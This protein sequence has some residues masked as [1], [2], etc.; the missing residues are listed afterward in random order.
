[1]PSAALLLL[2]PAGGRDALLACVS[3]HRIIITNELQEQKEM[4]QACFRFHFG[5]N[6][7]SLIFAVP[8]L[9]LG[10]MLTI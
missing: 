2:A 9:T 5:A 4:D 7:K 6:G 1:M 3:R 8:S 10:D